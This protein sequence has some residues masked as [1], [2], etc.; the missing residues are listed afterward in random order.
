MLLRAFCPLMFCMG[1]PPGP[2]CLL[3]LLRRRFCK[4]AQ[5][6]DEPYTLQEAQEEYK[7]LARQWEEDKKHTKA[8]G[9]TWRCHLCL[10]SYP[11]EGYGVQ[12]GHQKAEEETCVAPGVWRTCVACLPLIEAAAVGAD[13]HEERQCDTCLQLRNVLR[14]SGGTDTCSIC[15]L[16]DEFEV[17]TCSSCSRQLMSNK[18]SGRLDSQCRRLCVSCVPAGASLECRICNAQLPLDAFS[19]FYRAEKHNFRRCLAC[20]KSCSRCG[21]GMKNACSFA[22]AASWCWRCE[23]M[24]KCAV[25]KVEKSCAQYD[26]N[27]LQRHLTDNSALVCLDC[28]NL[29]YSP[30]DVTK[31]L[32]AGKHECG[33]LAFAMRHLQRWKEGSRQHVFCQ[34]C[35]PHTQTCDACG[36]K[37]P[38]M[39]FDA[40]M[41][42]N[43]KLRGS[44]IVC[45]GCETLGRSPKDCDLYNCDQC[46]ES[47]GHMRFSKYDLYNKKRYTRKEPLRCI[48]CKE[49]I[50]ADAR[51]RADEKRREQDYNK[52]QKKASD[53]KASRLIAI[54]RRD[55]SWRCKCK[56]IPKKQRAYYALFARVHKD[57]CPLHASRAG[58]MRWD[59]KNN[60]VTLE[61]I[62]FLKNQKKY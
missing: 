32:C 29:G 14:F 48:K 37:Q 60:G 21:R 54:L 12:R 27:V 31:Y 38:P 26:P 8:Q 53:E 52:M 2:A 30:A 36:T 28:R 7:V 18:W 59:G 3:K 5:P 4:P 13:Q 47:F 25:C 39:S 33:H 11:A 22:T 40:K 24:A 50:S 46:G 23:R 16:R 15:Q 41:G 19:K 45:R 61:D 20:S 34:S 43:H 44:K 6:G 51:A 1:E 9:L 56:I 62:L 10:F 17:F 49:V 35:Y 58:E 57:I 42:K 55:T